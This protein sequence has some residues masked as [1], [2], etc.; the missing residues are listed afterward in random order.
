MG[1]DGCLHHEVY[2][3]ICIDVD[4]ND[5]TGK[6]TISVKRELLAENQSN[7]GDDA[8]ELKYHC[9]INDELQSPHDLDLSG[10]KKHQIDD[11]VIYEYIVQHDQND[12][13]PIEESV[14]IEIDI[15]LQVC[16]AGDP[17]LPS[18]PCVQVG[19]ER[20][21]LIKT[22]PK[23]SRT[24]AATWNPPPVNPVLNLSKSEV[25]F[26]SEYQVKTDA[27]Y[28]ENTG[29]G[30]LNWNAEKSAGDNW[31]DYDPQEGSGLLN[32]DKSFIDVTVNRLLI[33]Q[34]ERQYKDH[35]GIITFHADNNDDKNITIKA[36]LVAPA[37]PQNLHITNQGSSNQFPHLEWNDVDLVHHYAIYRGAYYAS[38]DF[39][40]IGSSMSSSYTDWQVIIEDEESADD[41]YYYKVFAR[42][43]A[44][45]S[46]FSNQTSTWGFMIQEKD[47]IG[48]Q[49]LVPDIPDRFQL[50]NSYPNPGNPGTTIRFQLPE[51]SHIVLKV[52]NVRG[53]EV[54]TLIDQQM[55]AG[56]HEIYWDGC[57]EQGTS[58]VTG[59]YIFMM[60]TGDQVFH[61][62]FSLIK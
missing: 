45:R 44:G 23:I 43:G 46:D 31:F 58:V 12:E 29:G 53:E 41:K 47:Q 14:K 60:K 3:R 30:S 26:G 56:K 4:N 17:L 8:C 22:I 6:L 32:G 49:I 7:S 61:K 16:A 51:E 11:T 13:P 21:M 25:D 48:P 5:H 15:Y 1:S 55:T 40:S 19:D 57:N 24:Y 35:T 54:R 34:S 9:Y 39:D 27:F 59:M 10:G 2:A 33:P 62:K 18:D 52:F 36:S 20:L 28:V 38:G 37:A 42:N 50:E